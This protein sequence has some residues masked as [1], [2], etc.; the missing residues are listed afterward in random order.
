MKQPLEPRGLHVLVVEADPSRARV[1]GEMVRGATPGAGPAAHAGSLAE[2]RDALRGQPADIILLN[3]SLADCAGLATVRV[4]RA[5]APDAAVIVLTGPDDEAIAA[6]ALAM[7]VQD[8]LAMEELSDR[9]L[10]RSI[11]N[12]LAR[13]RA[14]AAWR[15][16]EAR[17]RSL[18][19]HTLD[20]VLLTTPDG[21]VLAA[22]PA[23]CRM[24]GYSE[25]EFRSLG[26]GAV[27]DRDDPR[28]AQALHRGA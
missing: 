12:A 15:A 1:L 2:A 13:T 20:A 3:P 5:L 17:F 26:R 24:F 7:G 4:I 28:L 25:E 11:R 10:A 16:S 14:E 23:A 21:A 18:F 9:L 6:E 19:E 27:A 22:N 8:Y